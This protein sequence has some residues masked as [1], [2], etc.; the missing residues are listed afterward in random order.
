M[1]EKTLGRRF[2]RLVAI[3]LVRKPS[4]SDQYFY[5]CICDCG[6]ESIKR[7]S[8]LS[9]GATTS[10]GCLAPEIMKVVTEENNKNLRVK[11]LNAV[12]PG[13]RFGRLVV[14]GPHAEY[15][16]GPMLLD[17]KCDCGNLA[18]VR[19]NSAR[20]GGVSSCGC[21]SKEVHSANMTRVNKEYR[22]SLGL[23]GDTLIQGATP[24]LR[25]KFGRELGKLVR[26]RDNFTCFLCDSRGGQL[27]VHHIRPWNKFPELRFEERNLITLCR[28]CH[29]EKAHAGNFKGPHNSIIAAQLS[30]HVMST[31]YPEELLNQVDGTIGQPPINRGPK[32]SPDASQTFMFNLDDCFINPACWIPPDL[33]AVRC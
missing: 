25:N 24:A 19:Q 15:T 8:N 4:K 22:E 6:T 28:V 29:F 18:T 11:R 13:E 1:A 21:F 16:R 14:I 26:S 7:G 32:P 33:L 9:S 2:G 17:C 20:K 3:E 12:I 30:H 5:K 27:N 10:C 23:D 31:F